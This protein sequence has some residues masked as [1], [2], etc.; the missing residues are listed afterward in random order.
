[1]RNWTVFLAFLCVGFCASAASAPIIIGQSLPLTG[2]GFTASNRVIA[3]ARAQV[4]RVNASG[5]IAGRPIELVTLD[6][7]GDP[8]RLEANFRTLVRQH[9]AIAF[10]NCLGERACIQAAQVSKE[11]RIPLVGPMSG[12]LEL[13]TSSNK[14]IFSA[15]ADDGQEADVLAR[16]LYS[17]GISKTI[18]L[19]DDAEPARTQALITALKRSGQQ[20]T[21]LQTDARSDSL[22]S[23]LSEMGKSTHQAVVIQLGYD[24]L[25]TLDQMPSAARVDVPLTVATLSSSAVAKLTQMFRGRVIGYTSVV[26]HPDATRLVVVRDLQRDADEFIGPEALTFEGM[27]AYIN[28]RIC[29]TALRNIGSSPDAKRMVDALEGLGALD[30]GGFRLMFGAGRHHGSDFVEIGMRTRDGRLLR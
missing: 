22:A 3:G 18:V 26:P 28:L 12:A 4:E 2:A 7:G 30:W 10:V 20:V 13:R 14:Y 9:G 5:G 15:R 8:Q 6:D 11:L 16:Q 21:R 19:T 17:I 29:M 23:R 1:M 24:A 25:N 27:E